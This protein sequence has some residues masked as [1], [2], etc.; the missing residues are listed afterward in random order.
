MPT[1]DARDLRCPMPLLKLK[2]ALNTMAA[3]DTLTLLATDTGTLRDIPA[4][5]QQS[6]HQLVSQS[7]EQGRLTFTVIKHSD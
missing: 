5:L 7:Q 6:G 1:V 4:F 2:L 3:G